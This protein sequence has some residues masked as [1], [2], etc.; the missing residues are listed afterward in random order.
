MMLF[1]KTRR[2]SNPV[3]VES[4]ALPCL[5]IMKKLSQVVSHEGPKKLSQ[6]VSHEGPKKL[7][8]VVS[9]EGPKKLSQVVS[10]E[11]STKTTNMPKVSCFRNVTPGLM[12][13][14]G[15]L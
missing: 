3:V 12:P 14:S 9:H 13:F 15:S 6:V 4:V 2:H 8:Q 7:S 5:A 10:Q 1:Q 11:D